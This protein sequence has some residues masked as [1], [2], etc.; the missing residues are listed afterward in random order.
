MIII[1]G[2]DWTQEAK[3]WNSNGIQGIIMQEKFEQKVMNN[4]KSGLLLKNKYESDFL[5]SSNENIK[6]ELLFQKIMLY[7]RGK[8][9]LPIV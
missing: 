9:K 2:K 6:K 4:E 8:N 1:L 7:N 5:K 3:A